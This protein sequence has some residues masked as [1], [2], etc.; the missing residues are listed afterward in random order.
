ML[1]FVWLCLTAPAWAQE[2]DDATL[3][4][5]E[6]S[7]AQIESEIA[8]LEQAGTDDPEA[9]PL[10]GSYLEALHQLQTAAETTARAEEHKRLIDQGAEEL[11][12]LQAMLEAAQ[13]GAAEPP[14][15]NPGLSLP[16]LERASDQG[17]AEV[18]ALETG[19]GELQAQIGAARARPDQIRGE[20]TT[21]RER[22][23]ELQTLL[24]Q[25]PAPGV[26][27]REEQAGRLALEA[28][29]R[30]LQARIG[31]LDLE[32][33][34]TPLRLDQL[35]LQAALGE[36]DLE[37]ARQAVQQLQAE[38][39][40]RRRSQAKQAQQAAAAASQQT[41]GKHPLLS[42]AARENTELGQRLSALNRDL[43]EIGE[44]TRLT[45]GLRQKI[46]DYHRRVSQQ[47]ELAGPEAAM[48]QF[49]YS[50]REKLNL[51]L[52]I[53]RTE[54]QTS[55]L[56]KQLADARVQQFELEERLQGLAEPA[57]RAAELLT[58]A[59]LA[60]DRQ[61]LLDEFTALLEDRLGLVERLRETS[62]RYAEAL[63]D[64]QL[65]GERLLERANQYARLLEEHLWL[66]PST[67]PI[68]RGWTDRLSESLR[69][70][71]TRE[72]WMAYPGPLLQT[73]ADQAL[74]ALLSLAGVLG[75]L[76]ARP[77]LRRRLGLMAGAIGKVG[78]DRFG[79]S[80]GALLITVLLA[81]PW[82]LALWSIGWLLASLPL[83]D[84]AAVDAGVFM[85]LAPYLLVLEFLRKLF[86][87]RG[88]AEAHFR[89]PVPV[90]RRLRRHL[91]WYVPLSLALFYVV[92]ITHWHWQDTAVHRET[93]GR[94][95]FL[96]VLLVQGVFV[97]R[98]LPA[99]P[100][101]KG[102][103]AASWRRAAP[104][105]AYPLLLGLVAA[106]AS[107]YF[108][109]AV[110]LFKL[111]YNSVLVGL[112]V[113]LTYALGL[114]WLVVAERR[115]AL[116]RARAR[117]AGE[118]EARAH[119][120]AADAAGEVLPEIQD[121][122]QLNISQVNYQ[123]RRILR[124]GMT[125]LA[126]VGLYWVWKAVEP[127]V[128][129]LDDVVLWSNR[130]G[131]GAAVQLLPVTLQDG[132]LAMLLFS[133][134]L[135]GARN[136]PG[137]LEILFLQRLALEPGLRYA[138]SQVARYAILA[139]GFILGIGL[140]GI[141]WQDIQWLVAAM[142][143]GLGFGLKDIFANFFSGLIILFE[144]PIRIGDTVTIGDVSGTVARI[145]IR[146]TTITDWDNK[147][148]VIPNQTLVV[149]PLINWTLSDQVTRITFNVGIA[150]GSEI[151]RAHRLMS[152]TVAAHPLVLPEPS[153]TVLFTGFGD[154][155]LEFQVRAFVN[156][157]AQR[158]QV[159]HDLH[160]DLAKALAGGGIEIPFPQRDLHLRSVP[161]ELTPKPPPD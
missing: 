150:Y 69:W 16:E 114:R 143:V 131:E 124:I 115:L 146:S 10:R 6:F 51:L 22:L 134:A 59:G 129:A 34:S 109:T 123:T 40:D 90:R 111:L 159:I 83:N 130:V 55:K 36:L 46:D 31:M 161:P 126:A 106:T 118:R 84:F 62:S 11:A 141:G 101:T 14:A 75:L 140:L 112:L 27:E 38:I 81:S 149:E 68:G 148:L 110:E 104:M 45:I 155:A 32:R 73:L 13:A 91:A 88:L 61:P 66:I 25:P 63:G 152:D 128:G 21:A 43:T 67:P 157:Q 8:K 19:L 47:L 142:G 156:E 28:E 7:E 135:A 93:L 147:E 117:R 97:W 71:L 41:E 92:S 35:E 107:G 29:R 122:L 95:A 86:V 60:A 64:M 151:E 5:G 54:R 160:M 119:R 85:G 105:L 100:A 42:T 80:L 33:L 158:L 116:V 18:S 78:I 113:Y 121:E 137:L 87:K 53:N 1:L 17:R 56:R 37:R 154:S 48:G 99:R 79:F 72:R 77:W 26:S 23:D 44:R 50:Q 82:A 103:E 133:V 58:E 144:R 136:L 76:I 132:L 153:P 30:A 39:T 20:L 96:L 57:Q 24:G 89:W 138:I 49:L 127:V 108:Y 70:L 74:P 4:N 120:A 2:P 139:A 65:E 52:D 125:A 15:A 3:G 102:A 94:L 145:R 12:R 98:V 9:G